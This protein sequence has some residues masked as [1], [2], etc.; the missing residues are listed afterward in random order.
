MIPPYTD[1]A[2]PFT[3]KTGHTGKTN[4]YSKVTGKYSDIVKPFSKK[5]GHAS[6]TS[7]Y[8]KKANYAGNFTLSFLLQEN[9]FN[10]LLEDGGRIY[11]DGVFDNTPFV[12]KTSAYSDKVNP[13]S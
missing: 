13:Y 8:T 5:T 11:L 10:L 6:K 9:K 3:K 7:P 12:K 1:K 2:K 4:P